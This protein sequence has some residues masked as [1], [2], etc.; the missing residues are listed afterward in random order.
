MSVGGGGDINEC[1]TQ[2]KTQ[3]MYTDVGTTQLSL[4]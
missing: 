4:I 3:L 1:I 2:I